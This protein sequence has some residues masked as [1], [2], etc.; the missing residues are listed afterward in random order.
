MFSQDALCGILG[1]SCAFLNFVYLFMAVLGL[2]YC[3]GLSLV[4]AS[5]KL[6][7]SCSVQAS[8]FG[9]SLVAEHGFRGMRALVVAVQELSCPMTCEIFPDHESWNQCLLPWLADS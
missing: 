8:H 4:V 5:G 2:H 3:L 9:D 6:L 1:F 7:S